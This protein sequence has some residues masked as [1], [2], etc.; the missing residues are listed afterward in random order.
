[1][2]LNILSPE[3]RVVSST[4]VSSVT[5]PG[6]EGQI[7]ILPQHADMIGTLETGEFAFQPLDGNPIHGVITSGFFEVRGGES[8]TVTAETV[9]LAKEIDP[10]RARTAQKK[11][12]NALTDP[13]LDS[14][15]FRKYELKLQRS[16]IRQQVAGRE[17]QTRQ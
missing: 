1:M 10:S 14:K 12:E 6:S 17:V 5:L 8:V 13:E 4:E 11:A 15:L 16:L 2:Q 9:E 3:K 7:Q